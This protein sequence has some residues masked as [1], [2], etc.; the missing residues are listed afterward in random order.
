MPDPVHPNDQLPRVPQI[1][2]LRTSTVK[3]QLRNKLVPELFEF[4]ARDNTEMEHT[5]ASLLDIDL[6]YLKL[7]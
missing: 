1:T 2:G 5:F 3:D 4:P 7:A 6:H